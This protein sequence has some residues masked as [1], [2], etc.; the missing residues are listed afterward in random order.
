MSIVL[1]NVKGAPLTFDEMDANFKELRDKVVYVSGDTLPTTNENGDAYTEGTIY[2]QKNTAG[3]YKIWV[4]GSSG[5]EELTMG[6]ITN[7]LE[8]ASLA[9]IAF[10]ARTRDDIQTSYAQEGAEPYMQYLAFAKSGVS[11]T[12]SNTGLNNLYM[13]SSYY[14]DTYVPVYQTYKALPETFKFYKALNDWYD[15]DLVNRYDK[16]IVLAVLEWSD[17]TKEFGFYE[18]PGASGFSN[19]RDVNIT[20]SDA[21]ITNFSNA[22]LILEITET[23][24]NDMGLVYNKTGAGIYFPQ[25]KDITFATS[26]AVDF[27]KISFLLTNHTFLV[28][29]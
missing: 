24:L 16:Q 25:F 23:D 9:G 27:A 20:Q 28:E 26:P 29:I 21:E 14:V 2:F 10:S 15:A 1:R 4:Y 8:I 19:I 22:Y 3:E 17:S 5:A 7:S 18:F 12:N 11:G 13:T 6:G